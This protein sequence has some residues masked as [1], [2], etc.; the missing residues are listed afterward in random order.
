MSEKNSKRQNSET[1]EEE[2]EMRAASSSKKAKVY[3]QMYRPEYCQKY[4]CLGPSTEGPTYAYCSLCKRSFKVSHGG[5]N[6]CTR[7]V[8]RAS[9][10]L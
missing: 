8:E 7:H 10:K 3:E 6:D 1:D 4:P 5:M 9:H 2:E